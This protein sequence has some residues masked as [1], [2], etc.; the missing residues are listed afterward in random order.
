[1]VLSQG[2]QLQKGQYTIE[3]EL[4]HSRFS[5]TYLA[6]NADGERWVIKVLD[7]QVLASLSPEEKAR[8]ETLFWQE[9]VKLAKCSRTPHI[10]RAEMPFKEGDLL[11]LPVEYLGGTSLADRPEPIL[12]ES[13]ALN[14]IQQLGEALT[15]VHRENLV[16]RDIRPANIFLRLQDGKV[17]AVLTN[18]ELA[19]ECDTELTRA[20]TKERTDGFSPPELYVS[21]EAIRP[22]TDVYSLAATLY[23]MLTGEVPV[24]A[25]SRGQTLPSPQNKN[26]DISGKTAKAI[27]QGMELV[28]TKRP[29]SVTAWLEQL[30]ITTGQESETSLM[31]NAWNW[32]TIWTA[33]AVIVPLLAGLIGWVVPHLTQDSPSPENVQTA[34]Q[35]EQE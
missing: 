15:V 27:L 30:G 7:P 17:E 32:Q 21:G 3:R 12:T 24:N 25:T 23:E 26:P 20:R 29:Q 34:P 28:A 33:A 14:Y 16:H 13:V 11:C 19:L 35:E 2:Q 9:A 4:G 22:Y 1:M 5:I 31:P 8:Q 10:A 6:T 18:F